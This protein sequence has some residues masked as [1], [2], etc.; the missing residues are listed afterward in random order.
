MAQRRWPPA[1]QRLVRFQLDPPNLP[2]YAGPVEG[3][4]GGEAA[5][6]PADG[7][8]ASAHA[9]GAA[10]P[11]GE[12][13][14]PEAAGAAAP[15]VPDRGRG[16]GGREYPD[17]RAA[18]GLRCNHGVP[19]G[20]PVQPHRVRRVRAAVESAGPYPDRDRRAVARADG[21][22]ALQSAR[23]RVAVLGVER[24]EARRVLPRARLDPAVL[25]RMGAAVAAR[26][27]MRAQRIR[28]W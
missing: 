26:R 19:L 22:G 23:A 24:A 7:A 3:W 27:G 8:T 1:C 21:R 10:D 2:R 11:A 12:A 9:V 6:Y 13:A 17:G 16:A 5:R 28:T 4:H 18:G 25:R 20:R 14:R 15:A